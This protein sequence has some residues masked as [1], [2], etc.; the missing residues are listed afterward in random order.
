MTRGHI[1]QLAAFALAGALGAGCIVFDSSEAAVDS[2]SAGVHSVSDA[3]S[4]MSGA[5]KS[6]SDSSSGGDEADSE[7][8]RRDVRELTAACVE[9][10]SDADAF[11]RDLGA[12]AE[13]H[14]I[15]NWESQR[16]TYR[17]IGAGLREAGLDEDGLARFEA[18]IPGAAREVR[19][20][21]REG[22]ES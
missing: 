10:G 12:V 15:T 3:V 6:S 14:G 21:I 9:S 2:V 5:S 8:Y 16:A 1:W 19:Q 17:A 4:W 7:A 22:W 18:G 20:A 13:R 11:L